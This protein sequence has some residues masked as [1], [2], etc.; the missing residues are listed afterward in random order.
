[1][2]IKLLSA[3]TISKIA[4][5]EVIERPASAI[6]EL[7][8][9]AIDAKSKTINIL[10]HNS[11]R[12]LISITDDGVGMNQ[13]DLAIAADRHTT[14][15]LKEE[16]IFDIKYFGFR[17]E[18][19]PSIAA[20]S[21]LNITSRD[22]LQ[23][24]A[25]SIDVIGG[26]KSETYPAAL[27]QGTKIEV[28]DLFFSTPTRLKFLKSER[29]ELHHIIDVLNKIALANHDIN[30]ILS[31]E[32]KTIFNYKTCDDKK[33]RI[34]EIIGT[35]FI[36]NAIFIDET[37]NE[38]KL[39]GYISIPTF[40]KSAPTDQYFFVNNRPVKDRTLLVALKIAYSDFISSDRYCIAILFLN[41]PP[42][43]VDV[44]A[45]PTKLE[46]RF[47][48]IVN[49][50]SIVIN[51]IKLALSSKLQ[52][53]S[54]LADK[55]IYNNHRKLIKD[56]VSE[57]EINK[58]NNFKISERKLDFQY[59]KIQ[60]QSLNQTNLN[61]KHI[62]PILKSHE[63]VN[64]TDFKNYPLGAAFGQIQDTYILSQ[65]D[66]GIIIVDQHAAH[67]RIVYEKL[68]SSYHD[69]NIKKQRLL[70]PEI[71]ELDQ[72][73]TTKIIEIGETLSNFGLSLE[74][75]GDSIIVNE[76]PILLSNANINNLIK[77]LADELVEY[78][79]PI[80]LIKL[81]EHVLES[82]ACHHSIRAGRKLNLSEMNALLREIETTSGS[83]QCN[84]G[85]PT[86]IKLKF[87]DIEKLF[88]RT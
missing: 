6:K 75:F 85:R 10:I 13:A 46:V 20:V 2:K 21:R 11:G 25:W 73:R 9:N 1:M 82:L 60:N 42:D 3:L 39:S 36:H 38:I 5:G 78:E 81:K 49:I 22:N 69:N 72:R 44:N 28:R 80:S 45:H 74:V 15:K 24:L 50:R 66:E 68:K 71:I 12:N 37:H 83:S 26:V 32:N 7:V 30:F 23:N 62:E 43:E 19:L 86:Y 65:I 84:H 14:S 88:G 27:S 79:E 54:M 16:D 8:E 48:D 34:Q 40:N 58:N 33:D 63:L 76:I 55:L 4:A 70:L 35:D 41:L 52:T 53:S 56:R 87:S 51:A 47:R 57:I 64:S 29:T 17:G 59:P 18:A 77:D 31:T 61:I 67:E